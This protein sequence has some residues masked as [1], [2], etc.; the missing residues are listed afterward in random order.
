VTHD[1]LDHRLT[2]IETKIDAM[3]EKLDCALNGKTQNCERM[4]GR[5]AAIERQIK[6]L[7][8]VTTAMLGGLATAI[9]KHIYG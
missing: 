7:W 1:D 9:L 3:S 6:A 2:V 8:A 4:R 5:V